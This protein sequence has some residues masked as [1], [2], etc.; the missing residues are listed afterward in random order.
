LYR[1][2]TF[3]KSNSEQ[4]KATIIGDHKTASHQLA[5]QGQTHT[6]P[7]ILL[8]KLLLQFSTLKN[9]NVEVLIRFE[10]EWKQ[11]IT[12]ISIQRKKQQHTKQKQN[13]N[14]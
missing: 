3:Q 6:S 2:Y 11:L 12:G 10:T 7:F 9:E 13:K 14:K 5:P 4:S 1:Q 8:T